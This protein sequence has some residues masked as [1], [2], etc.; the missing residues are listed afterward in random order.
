MQNALASQK[1]VVNVRFNQSAY[2]RQQN[3]STI[4]D[5]HYNVLQNEILVV[6]RK[7]RVIDNHRLPRVHSWY[8]SNAAHNTPEDNEKMKRLKFYGVAVTPHVA[9]AKYMIDQ[10][11]VA[12]RAGIC[13]AVNESGQTIHVG[14]QLTYDHNRGV[15]KQTGVP[16]NKHRFTFIRYDP[17]N[18]EHV[19]RGI[20]A[21]ALSNAKEHGHFDV[22]LVTERH[23]HHDWREVVDAAG[24]AAGGG[25]A[26][27]AAEITKFQEI[28]GGP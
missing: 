28:F 20:V 6:E 10:G 23:A 27:Y 4:K 12:C 25:G 5:E 3:S 1:L 7:Q 22:K 24:R 15:S 14:E 16:R 17:A 2:R 13:K 21:V 9:S 19:D 26:G 18:L 11:F 8:R